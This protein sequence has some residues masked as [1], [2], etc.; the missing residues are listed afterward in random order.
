[1]TDH[2]ENY[3]H[4]WG[5]AAPLTDNT[6]ER[7]YHLLAYHCLD[8]AAVGQQLLLH[9]PNLLRKFFPS[10]VFKDEPDREQW[11]V[12]IITFLLALHDIG[13][14]SDRFQNLIPELLK[15][16]KGYSYYPPYTVHH[17]DM[18]R[19]LFEKEIWQKI[20]ESDWFH[21]D[22]NDDRSDWKYVW[23]PWFFAVTGH[24]GIPPEKPEPPI[25]MLF[26]D[27]NRQSAILFSEVCAEIFLKTKF[28]YPL[29][30]SEKYLSEFSRS[31][32]LLAGLAVMSDWIGS[33][34]DHFTYNSTPM[35]LETYWKEYAIPQAEKAIRAFGIL[36]GKVSPETGM[37]AL[38]PD[39]PK[40]TPLQSFA[41]LCEIPFTPQLFIIEEATGSGKTETALV[42][43]HRLMAR[44]LAEGIYFGLPTMATANAMYD[45]MGKAY[46]HLFS[47]DSHP[48]LVLAHSGSKLSEKFRQSI[49]YSERSVSEL[50]HPDE[51]SAS[52]QCT[53]WLS[54]SR[55]KALLA[56]VGVGT[57]DQALI[58]VLPLHHQSLRLLGLSRNILIVD[59]VHAYDSYV[60]RV[61]ETLLEFHAA[62]GGSAI[63]LSATLPQAQRQALISAYSSGL[64]IDCSEV[65]QSHYPMVTHVTPQTKEPAEYP[66]QRCEMTHRT[67]EIEC[68]DD[69]SVIMKHLSKAIEE[70]GC[71]CWV[72]NTVDDAIETY[73]TLSK[74]FG[75]E[76]VLLFHARFTMGDRIKKEKE[77]LEL[78]GKE[79]TPAI[80]KGKILI[81][82]Q[83][84]EQSLDLDF[85]LMVTDLAPMDLII[86]R[87]GRLHRHND[88]AKRGNRGVPKLIVMS[89]PVSE[90]PVYEWY[91]T[92]FPKGAYVYP[93][94]GQLWLTAR[95][96]AERKKITMPD[97]ARLLIEGT[98]GESAQQD[99]PEMLIHHEIKADG[100]N[101]ADQATAQLNVLHLSNGYKDTPN[102]WQ[103]DA[104]TPTRLGEA[105]VTVLLLK[106]EN[107]VMHFCSS[108]PT[109]SEEFSQVSMS[110]RKISKE[111]SYTGDLAAELEKFKMT[112]ADKGRWRILVPLEQKNDKWQGKALDKNGK[113]VS[114]LYDSKLGVLISKSEQLRS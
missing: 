13:K 76:K 93:N 24:H 96:L 58:A 25:S 2:S 57:I 68:T 99:I 50:E 43:A 27:E 92:L 22:P 108:A 3:F 45:R 73:Q 55:K 47:R 23:N 110:D 33:N 109:F 26:E 84:V 67:I 83:V 70:G 59:E 10:D 63:L 29:V 102:Q 51:W 7:S 89:P 80:R 49:G 18:G 40:P 44:G 34:N 8:V 64:G 52:A 106:W 4:Y 104:R 97:D 31:S 88:S 56:Q 46:G 36:P 37:H 39:F 101:M 5:K 61:L 105:R 79:S 95:L 21:L 65:R 20:W 32:W 114:I 91:S 100:K 74:L 35:P 60:Q 113:V 107:S 42:L 14:F 75:D 66:I 41:E 15:E 72:K 28:L 11:C 12:G 17:T 1:M 103:N 69:P 38:F 87:S 6:N 94:H 81:A 86:Q 19:L 77:V 53:A 90:K 98:F 54:D 9:D 16:L 48:S 112:L 111:F 62:L 82:T 30:F 85:D 78:F 71:A